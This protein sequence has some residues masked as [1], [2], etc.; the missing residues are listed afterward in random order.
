MF[1]LPFETDFSSILNPQNRVKILDMSSQNRI[2]HAMPL[3]DAPKSFQAAPRSSQT[4][5]KYVPKSSKRLQN[6]SQ[7]LPRSSKKFP[8]GSKTAFKR[9]PQWTMVS[10]KAQ[11]RVDVSRFVVYSSQFIVHSSFNSQSKVHNPQIFTHRLRLTFDVSQL[12]VHPSVSP[13]QTSCSQCTISNTQI[14]SRLRQR[15]KEVSRPQDHHLY[16]IPNI[17]GF[18][19]RHRSAN[20]TFKDRSPNC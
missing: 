7:N 18:N 11:L 16:S 6:S 14:T 17:H 19:R 9:L 3:Q 10:F 12:T 1:L 13:S 4:A 8:R 2:V 20:C 15:Y 5:P